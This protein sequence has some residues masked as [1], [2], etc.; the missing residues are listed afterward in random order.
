VSKLLII[1][2]ETGAE[3]YSRLAIEQACSRLIEAG[4]DADIPCFCAGKRL[5]NKDAMLMSIN[6]MTQYSIAKTP[7][8]KPQ[9]AYSGVALLEGH[10]DSQD[11]LVA[12]VVA[13]NCGIPCKTVAEWIEEAAK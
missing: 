8:A 11:A 5:K 6:L 7:R 12:W 4:Y 1:G 9:R 13:K 2:P 3:N 10:E